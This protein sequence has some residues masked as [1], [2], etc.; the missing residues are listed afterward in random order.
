MVNAETVIKDVELTDEQQ[1][2]VT[3][4]QTTLIGHAQRI[5]E[6]LSEKVK[7]ACEDMDKLGIPKHRISYFVCQCAENMGV[8]ENHLRRLV[9]PEY[10]DPSQVAAAMAL[11]DGMHMRASTNLKTVEITDKQQIQPVIGEPV[12][13]KTKDQIIAELNQEKEDLINSQKPSIQN[14][15]INDL[16][17]VIESYKENHSR[18]SEQVN[19]LSSS[20]LKAQNDILRKKNQRMNFCHKIFIHIYDAPDLSN[21]MIAH[22]IKDFVNNQ[23]YLEY[24]KEA[25]KEIEQLEAEEQ[26]RIKKSYEEL[27]EGKKKHIAAKETKKQKRIEQSIEKRKKFDERINKSKIR[28][29]IKK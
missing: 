23:W 4:I 29:Q 25:R 19:T 18:L 2:H 20:A 12:K 17:Q 6:P 13:V 21:E 8:T 28:K 10:K 27:P 22:T 16:R 1:R 5:L 3:R 9:P 14:K 15:Q 24:G 11:H 7:Q 26:A